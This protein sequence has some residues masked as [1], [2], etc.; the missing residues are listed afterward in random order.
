MSSIF[1]TPS[2]PIGELPG[3]AGVPASALQLLQDVLGPLTEGF[4]FLDYV[5][6]DRENGFDLWVELL[7]P[8]GFTVPIPGTDGMALVLLDDGSNP[9]RGCGTD[10]EGYELRL[11]V[12][13]DKFVLRL[14]ALSVALRFPPS[15]LSP[16]DASES[17]YSQ[18][19]LFGA[20]EIDQTG[21]IRFDWDNSLTL[22]PSKIADTGMVLSV[23]KIKLDLS[24]TTAL[25]EVLAAGYG[26]DFRGVFIEEAKLALPESMS[27]LV[28]DVTV[29][30]FVAGSGGVSGKAQVTFN[31]AEKDFLGAKFALDS[32]SVT[33][34]HS[35][36]AEAR[37]TGKIT[38]PFFDQPLAV[39]LTVDDGG[40]ISLKLTAD[41]ATLRKEKVVELVVRSVLLE[42]QDGV[43]TMRFD[44]K[45]TPLAE[46]VAW[47]TFDVEGLTVDSH[48]D[49]HVPG[50]WIQPAKP[51]A[52]DF[53]G[54]SIEV[55]KVGFGKLSNGRKWLGLSGAMK[56][57]DGF[58]AGASVDG[59]RISWSDGS[60]PDVD[61]SV[62]G[63]GVEFEVSN[64]LSFKGAVRY[65]KLADGHRFD[66]NIRVQLIALN[67]QIDGI[68][69][70]GRAEG[71][72]YFG[73]YLNV[74]LPAGIALGPLPL[75][76]YG[77]AGLLAIQMEPNRKEDEAWYGPEGS[78]SWL[79]PKQQVADI[80]TKWDPKGG[81]LA[82]GAG[83]TIGTTDNGF[84]FSGK[85]LLVVSLPGPLI[86]LD[87][88]A[89][90]LKE[91][92]E[93]SGDKLPLFRAL[94][95]LDARPGR[96]SLLFALDAAYKYDEA[97]GYLVD[98][99]GGAEAFFNFNDAS[100]WHI[101]LGVREPREQRI[102]AEI[103]R[104]FEANSYF[105][106]DGQRLAT[107]AWV[108]YQKRFQ[109]GP[110]RLEIEAW[111]ECNAQISWK[112]AY[113]TAD[114]SLHGGVR[115]KVFR[116][117][118]GL[119]VDALFAIGAFEPFQVRAQLRVSL[120]LPWP[121]KDI[122][123]DLTLEWTRPTKSAPPIPVP[124]RELSI[125]H[126]R[127][128]TTWPLSRGK[129]LLPNVDAGGG[130]LPASVPQ[131]PDNTPPL[132]A[133]PVVPL[134][135][136]PCVTFARP[137]HDDT[138]VGVNPQPPNPEY[139]QIGDPGSRRGPV[140]VRYALDAVRLEA[141]RGTAWARVASSLKS[142]QTA[143]VR[144]L[145][146][147][148]AP[149][150]GKNAAAQDPPG[151]NMKLLLWS[152][153]G[154][155]HFRFS[156]GDWVKNLP[157]VVRPPCVAPAQPARTVCVNFSR[158]PRTKFRSP[159]RW[160]EAPEL[161]LAWSD[162]RA[163][164][165]TGPEPTRLCLG[166][167]RD[168]ATFSLRLT[169]PAQEIEITAT[170]GSRR[171]ALSWE[172]QRLTAPLML[173]PVYTEGALTFEEVARQP[174][175]L[176]PPPPDWPNQWTGMRIDR[177]V[178]IRLPFPASFR[179]TLT[180]Q[181]TAGASVQGL[182]GKGAP[183]GPPLE[184]APS[185][186]APKTT[187]IPLPTAGVSSV[188]IR[189]K[190]VPGTSPT[191]LVVHSLLAEEAPATAAGILR[192][193]GKSAPT[194]TL[195]N[196]VLTLAGDDLIG[197]DVTAAAL[198]IQGICV[199]F[200]PTA[201]RTNEIANMAGAVKS[202]VERWKET[203]ETLLPN[204]QYRLAV[205]T[206][207]RP[208]DRGRITVTEYG[209]FRT[210]GP[211]GLVTLSVP[212]NHPNADDFKRG[213]GLQDL[214]RYVRQTMPATVP[215]K[216]AAPRLATS[217]YRRYDLGVQFNE[218]YVDFMYRLSQ[219]DLGLYLYDANN[220]PVRDAEG[221]LVLLANAWGTTPAAVLSE[222]EQ[223]WLK[224][225]ASCGTDTT[226][227]ETT[228]ARDTVLQSA[229]PNQVLDP[230]TLYEGRLIPLLLHDDFRDAPVGQTPA[231]W[232]S[233]TAGAKWE[234]K[235]IDSARFVAQTNV[236]QTA[237]AF[238][239][240]APAAW[241]DVRVSAFTSSSLDATGIAFR[242]Q[243]PN[244]HYNFVL[245][246]KDGKRRLVRVKGGV[247][248]VLKEDAFA[249]DPNKQYLQT[250]EAAGDTIAAYQD[251]A[252]VFSVKDAAHAQGTIGLYAAG[253]AE[254]RFSDV[255]V[256]DFRATAPVVY[257][258]PF[259][260]SRFVNFEHHMQSYA[261]RPRSVAAAAN[262]ALTGGGAP[263]SAVSESEHRTYLAAVAA[264]FGPAPRPVPETVE[265]TRID[266]GGKTVALLLESPEPIAWERTSIAAAA[267]QQSLV[268]DDPP[269]ALKIVDVTLD[270]G[271]VNADSV[272]LLAT[273]AVDLTG[274]VVEYR[275]FPAPIDVTPPAIATNW[276]FEDDSGAAAG[277]S[278]QGS[279]IGRTAQPKA[280]YA[281]PTATAVATDQ[282]ILIR[283][284]AAAGDVGA[285]LRY[286]DPRNHY[287]VVLH[288]AAPWPSVN[289]IRRVAGTETTLASLPFMVD[290]TRVYALQASMRGDRI[291]VT[292]DGAPC[293]AIRDRGLTSGRAGL[294]CG[295][296]AAAAFASVVFPAPPAEPPVP[297]LLDEDFRASVPGRWTF[298][299]AAAVPSNVSWKLSEG[300]LQHLLPARA[301]STPGGVAR[302]AVTG[303]AGW[304]D[305]RI[306]ARVATFDGHA[307]GVA[308]RYR[309]PN[310]CYR[311]SLNGREPQRRQLRR[312]VN[313]VET[314]LWQDA[315]QVL[316]GN[317][318]CLTVDCLGPV[319]TMYVNGIRAGSVTD[320]TF[321]TGRAGVYVTSYSAAQCTGFDVLAAPWR[322][323]H[324]FAATPKLD[325]GRKV[326]VASAGGAGVVTRQGPPL[327]RRAPYW[328]SYADLRIVSPP[329]EPGHARR[330]IP[331][332]AFQPRN[333]TLLRKG[334]GGG[335]FIVLD[336]QAQPSTLSALALELRF[337]RK[338]G[339]AVLSQAG[340]S[341][342]EV[343]RIEI[344]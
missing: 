273:D 194:A 338:L 320:A 166:N 43:F 268:A 255:R 335:V 332:S 160:P 228:I 120:E 84:T 66:G 87:G 144:P 8:K 197:L 198:C 78:K 203:G 139:E 162:G 138:L 233:A 265:V 149:A 28:K 312:V 186:T 51:L 290:A 159:Y 13:G 200:G 58:Q 185:P 163:L 126:L 218:N 283:T 229:A 100:D 115:V 284:K 50:G 140:Q 49:I 137:V 63:V 136:R 272:T 226:V 269:G 275:G 11:V 340:D 172:Q 85:L 169:E 143:G 98:I 292:L 102:R 293:C 135:A 316:S 118:L 247:S 86:M 202:A 279:A 308:F 68:L 258:F 314:L 96:R 168:A 234:I 38:V 215:P 153:S 23:S 188:V 164:A 224:S 99:K 73:I 249:F 199:R 238:L 257:R 260:T 318:F 25:P 175:V 220:R 3:D 240:R 47:P 72:N 180:L 156:G 2:V 302:Y 29:T 225:M 187:W 304:S 103:L 331:P 145:F 271:N 327:D 243:S 251:G 221:R 317:D 250:V 148:W 206:S 182:D 104:L 321:A 291:R 264:L 315:G 152:N 70:I 196:G 17:Q 48:G 57:V 266:S 299:D 310:N 301:P 19:E 167:G 157:A 12:D 106:L 123:V 192:S 230:A 39:A 328:S 191:L 313:G 6:R 151:A 81:A 305:Y 71:V 236:L 173:P 18:L 91:R 35:V 33:L 154:Y 211:P 69:V 15:M 256:D 213:N 246:R 34:E 281:I 322:E 209:Y 259:A 326:R 210:E 171:E 134:D 1:E 276:K 204:T 300:R 105:M 119:S 133:A 60:N 252:L 161:E 64:V 130:F 59:L 239:V 55:S 9:P 141:W 235:T 90:L 237:G 270:P 79:T 88:R 319:I 282:A 24:R 337:Q 117:G 311:F 30:S 112:Q 324:R 32:V 254:A 241:N 261:G 113:L 296:G 274:H 244:D 227:N 101:H 178:H 205:T 341:S 53:H 93:L 298:A 37:V 41:D 75:S 303:E 176:V 95:I 286:T 343:T 344:A 179:I 155:D 150:M 56:L 94:A 40:T 42:L 309:D 116:F 45:V 217:F 20:L 336:P 297:L 323:Y 114:A 142:E 339:D 223:A 207:A 67:I 216:G 177:E 10:I 253:R 334:D 54:F 108:G 121:L 201:E 295:P 193:A 306:T 214:V 125:E 27:S 262:L 131:G 307:V 212:E 132:A 46:G 92:A 288:N 342:D 22:T 110:A 181:G 285:V 89:N 158:A 77:F 208:T 189:N 65:R 222:H 62:E 329:G 111:I 242:Y 146:G 14:E 289:V 128:S 287:R 280:A 16:A 267:A 36:L 124:L 44:G 330:A 52:L 26:E 5:I 83:V 74:E 184:F 277:W 107:G 127:S 333:V 170:G 82:V 278:V 7:F 325:A 294:F 76:L 97:N 31:G 248:T 21:D 190:T 122:D 195:Q 109:F 183:L 219:R 147:S 129:L 245:D 80:D 232:T 174:L 4:S 61:V 165:A 231:G 263:G